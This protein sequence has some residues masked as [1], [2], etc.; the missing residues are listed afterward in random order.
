M[1]LIIQ[2]LVKYAVFSNFATE[3][4]RVFKILNFLITVD[5]KRN[6]SKLMLAFFFYD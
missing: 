4:V 6:A 5:A 3:P 1:G 2:L